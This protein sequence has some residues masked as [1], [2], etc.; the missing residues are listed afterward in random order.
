MPLVIGYRLEKALQ[1]LD[2]KYNIKITTTL[3]PYKDKI[4]ERQGNSAIVVRQKSESDA[5]QLTTGLF[6]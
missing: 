5:I 3:S 4:E 6:K 1:L 2:K